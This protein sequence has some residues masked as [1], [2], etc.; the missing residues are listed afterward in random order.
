MVI[1]ME[2][3]ATPESIEKVKEKVIARGCKPHLIYGTQK[4]AVALTGS[5]NQLEEEEFQ[6]MSGVQEVL[7]VSKK[8]KLVSREVKNEDSVFDVGGVP[9]GGRELTI[10]AGPCSI[11]SRDQV[12]EIAGQ[13]KEMGI[14]FFRAGA[15]KPRT[16]PYAFQGLKETGLQYLA[17]I[18]KELGMLIVTEA[19]DSETLD[20]VAEVAD[21]IQIGARNMQNYSLLEKV[22]R[23][24]NPILLKRGLAATIEDLL[25]SAEYIVNQGNLNVILCERGIRTFETYTR[26]TL[27]LNAVPVCKKQSHLPMFVDPSHGIGIWEKVP[28]MAMAGVACG[29][30]GLIIEVH[31]KPEEALSDGFQSLTPKTFKKLLLK[32]EQLAPIVDKELKTLC[33]V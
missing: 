12:F 9:V 17:D 20:A 27:D 14:K 25:M 8:Y 3:D 31:H 13:L 2:I 23:L 15:Y 30:D 29:A 5:T 10:I 32:L 28:P 4:I 6:L 16:S 22:G 33:T 18:K 26:N 7:R 21:I 11:E 1:M 19:K 24:K